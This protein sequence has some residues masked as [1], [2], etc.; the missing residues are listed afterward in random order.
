MVKTKLLIL[1]LL[2]KAR[3]S[4][5]VVTVGN[6]VVIPFHYSKLSS[7]VRDARLYK[8]T[9]KVYHI[10]IFDAFDTY[11]VWNPTQGEK[12]LGKFATA[13]QEQRGNFVGSTLKKLIAE[14][15]IP[16]TVNQVSGLEY[17]KNFKVNE[18]NMKISFDPSLIADY[19]ELQVEMTLTFSSAPA[20]ARENNIKML[21]E[22][23]EEEGP[24]HNVLLTYAPNVGRNG[25]Y[26]LTLAV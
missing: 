12:E 3:F 21:K 20:A 7:A 18:W 24:V 10:E 19:P 14:H 23:C 1:H 4:V 8:K 9:P 5:R 22:D 26:D 11:W 6:D 2:T 15:A 25:W 16:F 17:N 13:I